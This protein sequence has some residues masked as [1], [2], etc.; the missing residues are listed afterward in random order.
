MHQ[1]MCVCRVGFARCGVQV[2]PKRRGAFGQG[3]R[4][5]LGPVAQL[6]AQIGD[7][8]HPFGRH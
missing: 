1:A 4:G 6:G 2:K 8:V 3:A 5:S 7:A